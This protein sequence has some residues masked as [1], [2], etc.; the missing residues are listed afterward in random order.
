MS[1]HSGTVG[2]GWREGL[3]PVP[4]AFQPL[5]CIPGA[6]PLRLQ[7]ASE[8]AMLPAPSLRSCPCSDKKVAAEWTPA[9]AEEAAA[10]YLSNYIKCFSMEDVATALAQIPQVGPT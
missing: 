8:L 5:R 1:A 2:G 10:F 9:M 6:A 7:R 4:R 3:P